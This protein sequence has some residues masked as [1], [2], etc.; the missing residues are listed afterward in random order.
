MVHL[1][2]LV[3]RDGRV[4]QWKK[5]LPYKHEIQ[6]FTFLVA[7]LSVSYHAVHNDN[8]GLNL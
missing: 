7:C 8:N 5:C 6:L 3:L 4:P 2:Y 1:R